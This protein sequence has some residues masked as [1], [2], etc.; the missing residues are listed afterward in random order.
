MAV[1]ASECIT[2]VLAGPPAAP[3]PA[4]DVPD[5]PAEP[6]EAAE[7]LPSADGSTTVWGDPEREPE[8]GPFYTMAWSHAVAAPSDAEV[9]MEQEA[10]AASGS[11]GWLLEGWSEEAERQEAPLR[12]PF[13]RWAV[14]DV[15]G[16][17]CKP[18]ATLSF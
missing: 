5:A 1:L 16:G 14:V 8:P 11:W 18:R 9:A 7:T 15:E 3:A 12:P 17:H 6:P 2:T 13:D 4:E 10:A